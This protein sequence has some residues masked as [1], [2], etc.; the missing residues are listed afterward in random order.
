MSF[1]LL[2]VVLWFC[3]FSLGIGLCISGE[4][5]IRFHSY[6]VGGSS[7]VFNSGIVCGGVSCLVMWLEWSC[8]WDSRPQ[9]CVLY[10]VLEEIE[11]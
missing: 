6:L 3:A 5:K 1:S 11:V 4:G 2:L 9:F 7:L 8:K 10:L